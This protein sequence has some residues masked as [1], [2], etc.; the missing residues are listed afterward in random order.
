MN[1]TTKDDKKDRKIVYISLGTVLNN[2]QVFYQNCFKAFEKT[3]YDV[4][5]SIGEKTDMRLL[6]HTGKFHS[7]K[8]CGSDIDITESRCI[9]YTLWNE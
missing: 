1:E 2:N 3:N 4:I 9:Y 5:M 8:R 6:K 7:E